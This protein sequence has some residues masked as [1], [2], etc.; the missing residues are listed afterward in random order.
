MRKT[1][2]LIAVLS[3]AAMMAVSAP[4][5]M[6][7]SFLMEAYAA[8]NGWVE[9]DGGWHFYDEDGYMESN[10]WKK[11]GNDWYYLNDDGDVTVNE[12]VDEY[13]VDGD[14]KMVKNK[15]VSPEGEETYDSPDSAA[16]TE[17]NYFD[18]NGKIVTSKWM[19]VNNNWYYFDGDGIMQTGLLELDGE[20]YYLGAENDGARRTGWVL[21]EE[22]TEDTDD[23]EIWCYFD[24]DGKLVKDQID[25]KI[26]GFYYTFKDGQ[27]QTGWV[28]VSDTAGGSSD[29]EEGGSSASNPLADYRYYDKE[30]G[31]K[32]ASG[33]YVIEGVE[34]ISE[35]GEEYYFYFKDGK[36]YYSEA[37]GL[38]LFNINSERYAFNEKG[39]MQTGLQKLTTKDGTEANYYFGDDGIMKT[40]KQTIYD[41]DLEENQIWYFYPSGSK[42]GQGYTGEK[43]NRVYAGGLMKK[44]DPELRYEPVQAGDKTYL[45]NTSGTI[46]KSSASSTSDAKP[47]LGKG[48]RDYKDSN[49]TVWTVDTEGII[50]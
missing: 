27:M 9:E 24:Q 45:V 10:T 26:D 37:E 40:G 13:Y 23:E 41:E 33:W 35:E 43:D 25:R 38:E 34:G 16:D 7:S 47:E 20:T 30:L 17:W 1:T 29:G 14:G 50:Q 11:R 19:S 28:K 6:R 8:E 18:K 2:K 39:E 46:Q 48:F 12:R 36:P 15:W 44:A 21:L 22:I 3:A 49:D 32:R 4:N 5:V 31:G 42:K